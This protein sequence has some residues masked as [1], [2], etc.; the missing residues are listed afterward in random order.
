MG[1][2]DTPVANRSYDVVVVGCGMAGLA[3]GIAASERGADVAVLEKSPREH[4]GGHLR[5]TESFRVPTADVEMDQYDFD[6]PDYTPS[7]FY[8]DIM[9]VTNG[10]ADPDLA[11]RLT[12]EAGP[13][14]EWLTEHVEAQGM[15]WE[16]QPPH[17]G[18]VAGRTWHDG[19]QFTEALTD[20][21]EDVGVDLFFESPARDL[22]RAP[23]GEVEAVDARVED[24]LLRF[25]GDAIVLASGA[26]ESSAEKR[27]RYYGPGYE[28]MKVRGSRYNTGEVLE[29][30]LDVDA[31][32]TGEWSGAH[33][34]I[35]DAMSPDVEGGITR[36][37][38]YQYGVMIN[39]E[40]ER[41]VDEG[42]D[43]RTQTYAKFGRRIFEQPFHEAFIVVD[44]K[45]V[46]D[47]AHMGPGRPITADSIEELA[48]RLDV[49]DVEQTVETIEA[50]NESAE[51]TLDDYDPNVLDG[52]EA[53]DVDPRKS[54][55][56]LPIDEPPYTG[57][58][59]TGGITF[60][61][62]GVAV[63]P[64]AEVLDTSDRTI[65][66][67][68]AAGNATGGLFYSNY[69]GGTGLT[70]AAVFG[71]IAGEEAADYVIAGG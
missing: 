16:T 19:E 27:T 71:K 28:N 5:F 64:D 46:D 60:G 8:S 35:I 25:E 40:G 43:A 62:G 6:I 4:R 2:T 17:P 30:A 44:S 63:T 13:M 7:E 49:G 42:E 21:A 65:P 18:Y 55:W 52:M 15:T 67:L 20:A 57:Y 68:Y 33:M 51:G 45:V 50:F 26:Y 54:N 56:A 48:N 59:V 11:K 23:T 10:R 37:D 66:G 53:P 31:K 12:E 29:M 9:K 1:S 14:I 34:A 36:I 69:P 47:V 24:D 41:F 39:H 70:N 58:P 38:G 3:A 32:A 61:F 22:H